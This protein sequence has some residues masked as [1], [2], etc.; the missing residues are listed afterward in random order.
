VARKQLQEYGAS[1]EAKTP[2]LPPPTK[3]ESKSELPSVKAETPPLSS[4]TKE[5][6][7]TELPSVK[8]ETPPPLP[9]WETTKISLESDWLCVQC[10]LI[11]VAG[12]TKR[13]DNCVFWNETVPQVLSTAEEPTLTDVERLTRY[14]RGLPSVIHYKVAHTTLQ[15]KDVIT[16]EIHLKPE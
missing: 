10:E 1:E 3:V 11:N 15:G 8:A 9:A 2:P 6:R 4:P 14:L 13:C 7:K 12:P 5:E 16:M